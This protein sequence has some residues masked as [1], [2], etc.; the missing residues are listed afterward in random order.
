MNCSKVSHML[1]AYMDGELQ[2]V[3]HRLVH[4]HLTHCSKCAKEYSGL[5]Q[6]KRL[7]SGMRMRESDGDLAASI[8]EKVHS[9]PDRTPDVAWTTINLRGLFSVRTLMI[10]AP[11]AAL[12]LMMLIVHHPAQNIITWHPSGG[13]VSP[14]GPDQGPKVR[15]S[16]DNGSE[17]QS[18][19]YN[20]I[21]ILPPQQPYPSRLMLFPDNP[22]QLQVYMLF[23]GPKH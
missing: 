1:S 6:M 15:I 23:Q 22:G 14:L 7:L 20:T 4:Q 9:Q 12:T 2:G 10:A 11:L 17:V 18:V 21:Q 5:L 16:N 13:S 19:N 8:I 3:E